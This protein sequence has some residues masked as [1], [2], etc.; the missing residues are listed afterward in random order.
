MADRGKIATSRTIKSRLRKIMRS[1]DAERKKRAHQHGH[2][3]DKVDNYRAAHQKF[4]G[5]RQHRRAR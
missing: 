1:L 3:D 2:S 4:P 5:D